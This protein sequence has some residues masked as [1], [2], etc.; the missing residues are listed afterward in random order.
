MIRRKTKQRDAILSA[1]K[2]AKRPLTRI[3]L[4]ELARKKSPRL[5]FATVNRAVN[6]LLEESEIVQMDY[7]GQPTRIEPRTLDEHPHLLCV[8]C[9]KS[10]NLDISMPEIGKLPEV[11]E[12]KITGYEVIYFGTC[13]DCLKKKAS[14]ASNVE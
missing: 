12:G 7:P 6:A 5:G 2:S 14:S 4:W 9:K 13:K 8:H 3:E 10:F 1:L 11:P